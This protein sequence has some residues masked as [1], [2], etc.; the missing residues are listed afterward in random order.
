MHIVS[1]LTYWSNFCRGLLTLKNIENEALYATT[2][3]QNKIYGWGPTQDIT[4]HVLYGN[5]HHHL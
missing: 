2:K 4:I 1:V 5:E 3:L